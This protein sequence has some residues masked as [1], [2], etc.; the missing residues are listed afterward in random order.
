MIEVTNIKVPLDAFANLG[1]EVKADAALPPKLDASIKDAL[2][3]KLGIASHEIETAH[4][5]RRSV[6]ARKKGEVHF[7]VSAA[8]GLY[9]PSAEGRLLQLKDV[10]PS[11]PYEPLAI[12]LCPAPGKRPYVIGA[13]PA[14]LF[15]ALFLARAG[16]APVLVERGPAVEE[17]IA[18]VSA[19][20]EAGVL[21]VQANVQF[22]EGGAGTFSDGKLT[23]NVKNPY[24]AHVLRW[25][26]EA[27]APEEILWHAKPHLGTDRL[28]G[29]VRSLRQ[30]IREAGGEVLFGTQATRI[31]FEGGAVAS[32]EVAD[33]RTGEAAVVETDRVVLACGHSAGDTFAMLEE[34]G[35]AM[36]A[37]PFSVGVRIEHPQ[38]MVDA[39]QYGPSAGHAALGAAEYKLAVHLP[40]GRGCY[41][42]CMCP[43]GEVV[44]AASEEGATVTNGMSR[45]ARDGANAN[46]AVLVGVDPADFEGEGPLAG[47]RF[48]QGIERAAFA[49]ASKAGGAPYQLPVQ[50]VGDFLSE[51]SGRPSDTVEPS[52]TRGVV[53]ADLRDCLPAFVADAIAQALPLLNRKLPGFADGGAVMA[54]VETRSSS[55]VRILRDERYQARMRQGSAEHPS[56]LYL[57]GEGPGY[58]GGIMSAAADGL[59]VAEALVRE[60]STG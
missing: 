28:T 56:G 6:D 54:G 13:G 38:S 14:G 48:R 12:P 32:L 16:L 10:K 8:V 27:G 3:S 43:G 53:W 25:F 21:D 55:P 44:S 59:R 17:R 49:T 4:L 37:K 22:G 24:C 40:N 41:T 36:E 29:I 23:T 42:F 47:L 26:V 46:S 15:A 1:E 39:V 45:F 52:C 18:A 33:A 31:S 5:L 58:A 30:S 60:A 57:C 19:F 50:T 11:V 7:V 9:D 34:A 20:N 35:I 51:M 2:A